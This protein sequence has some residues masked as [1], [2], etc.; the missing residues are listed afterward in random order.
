[1]SGVLPAVDEHVTEH[2]VVAVTSC[3]CLCFLPLCMC[4]WLGLGKEASGEYR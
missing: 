3:N 4:A 1:M 2:I